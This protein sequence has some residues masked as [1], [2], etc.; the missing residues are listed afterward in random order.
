MK[1]RTTIPV[2][3]VCSSLAVSGCSLLNPYVTWERPQSEDP[4]LQN[5]IDYANRA[6][7][8][9]NAA[10]GDQALLTNGLALGLIPLSAAAIGLGIHQVSGEAV[11]ALGLTGA[12]AFGAG[13]WLS[14]TPRQRIYVAGVK[15]MSCAVSAILPLD[16]SVSQL[17]SDLQDLND[18]IS[19]VR[20]ARDD[21]GTL[22]AT[23]EEDSANLRVEPALV[24]RAKQEIDTASALLETATQTYDTG[25]VLKQEVSR[26]G[27]TIVNAVDDIAADVNEAIVET[28]PDLSKLPEIINSLAQISTQFTAPPEPPAAPAEPGERPEDALVASGEFVKNLRTEALEGQLADALRR[29]KERIETLASAARPVAATVNSVNAAKPIETLKACGVATDQLA[30]DITLEPPGPIK[31]AQG[32]TKGLL[33]K[34]GKPPFSARLQGDAV[35]GLTITQIDTFGP[36]FTIKTTGETPSGSYTIYVSDSA[37]HRKFVKLDVNGGTTDGGGSIGN[38]GNVGEGPLVDPGSTGTGGDAESTI[39]APLPGALSLDEIN[40]IRAAISL[41][42]N[43]SESPID[44]MVRDAIR[45]IQRGLGLMGGQV[46]GAVG[47]VT[48]LKIIKYQRDHGHVAGDPLTESLVKELLGSAQPG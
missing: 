32:E 43:Q 34:G 22:V 1:F 30:T 41:P 31:M 5:G 16:L 47:P 23:I 18:A 10:V 39:S 48:R 38:V 7:D 13:T 20:T 42:P 26:A 35:T 28:Q 3:V 4:S 25:V 14:S 40:N 8:A 12:A 21:V 2:L 36:A 27:Q 17:Q 24:A 44:P 33:I 9:Y 6:K 37:N 19:P 11:T 29:L 45:H 46:D 15:A